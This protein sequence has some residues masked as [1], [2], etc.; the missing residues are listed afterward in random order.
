[1]G[2]GSGSTWCLVLYPS[3]SWGLQPQ[4]PPV[5]HGLSGAHNHRGIGRAINRLNIDMPITFS[6]GLVTPLPNLSTILSKGPR[7][8][9][10]KNPKSLLIC[11]AR[12]AGPDTL[13][14][15]LG[16]YTCTYPVMAMK[17]FV[18]WILYTCF[19]R[20]RQQINFSCFHLAFSQYVTAIYTLASLPW[21]DYLW[22]EQS[23]IW[24]TAE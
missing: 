8:P 19:Y 12:T 17:N 3:H 18:H 9:L 6:S 22:L 5:L 24:L 13:T 20:F 11:E 21:I 15:C 23:L 1:M 16:S 7:Q 4:C 2:T 10:Q 14:S